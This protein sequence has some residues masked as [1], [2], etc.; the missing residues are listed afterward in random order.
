MYSTFMQWLNMKAWATNVVT[1]PQSEAIIQA[2]VEVTSAVKVNHYGV[3]RE[4]ILRMCRAISE[5][6]G[7]PYEK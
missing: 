2:Q 6:A 4:Q 5:A 1:V 7:L 3:L